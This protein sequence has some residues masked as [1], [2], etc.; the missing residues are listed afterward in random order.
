MLLTVMVWSSLDGV[1][2][3]FGLWMTSLLHTWQGT[4]RIF[5]PTQKGR[6]NNGRGKEDEV[7]R[8]LEINDDDMEY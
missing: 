3:Y 7:I 1:A 6:G 5:R 2:M 8:C 4:K